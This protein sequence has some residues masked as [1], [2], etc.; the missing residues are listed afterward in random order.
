MTHYQEY[1]LFLPPNCPRKWDHL[2][3]PVRL[4][5]DTERCGTRG[6]F[7]WVLSVTPFGLL[8]C[9]QSHG[10]LH[11]GCVAVPA[12]GRRRGRRGTRRRCRSPKRRR[13][14]RSPHSVSAQTA[15]CRRN[16]PRRRAVRRMPRCSRAAGSGLP[17]PPARISASCASAVRCSSCLLFP[18]LRWRNVFNTAP[19]GANIHGPSSWLR[20][21]QGFKPDFGR[22]IDSRAGHRRCP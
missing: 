17:L 7:R 6:L 22:G 9:L 3:L 13:R 2:S 15:R 19:H 5:S 8:F 20:G 21:G 10:G 11:A 18:V 14:G 1:T 4:D 16:R 12:G